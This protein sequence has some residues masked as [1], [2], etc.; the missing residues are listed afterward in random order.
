MKRCDH[1]NGLYS[2]YINICNLLEVQGG[3]ISIKTLEAAH[4]VSTVKFYCYDCKRTF[5][6]SNV[7]KGPRWVQTYSQQL[8]VE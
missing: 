4:S 5:Y 7:N 2:E 1:R 3:K 6:F 8:E